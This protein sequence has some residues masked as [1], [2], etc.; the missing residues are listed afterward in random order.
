MLLTQFKTLAYFLFMHKALTPGT[1]LNFVAVVADNTYIFIVNMGHFSKE[2][3]I[4][5]S[6]LYRLKG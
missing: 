5:I 1:S 4:L 3:R 6:E 2:D